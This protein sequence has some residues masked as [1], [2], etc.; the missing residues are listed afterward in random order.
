[1]KLFWSICA[2][3]SLIVLVLHFGDIGFDKPGKLGLAFEHF[4]I[5]TSLLIGLF[6][7][8]AIVIFRR[9]QWTYFGAQLILLFLAAA[10]V[11]NN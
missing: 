11:A 10:G 5:L 6:V 2:V 9:K 1:M 4:L 3:Q 7:A 8:A